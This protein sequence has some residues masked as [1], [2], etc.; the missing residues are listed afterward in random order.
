MRQKLLPGSL[1]N[2]ARVFCPSAH[3]RPFP[4][5]RLPLAMKTVGIHQCKEDW[6]RLPHFLIDCL[7]VAY[8]LEVPRSTWPLR[9]ILQDRE[10]ALTLTAIKIQPLRS[11]WLPLGDPLPLVVQLQYPLCPRSK[12]PHLVQAHTLRPAPPFLKPINILLTWSTTLPNHSRHNSHQ[13][14]RGPKNSRMGRRLPTWR[15]MQEVA[16]SVARPVRVHV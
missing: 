3:L 15:G 14:P 9:S 10:L 7:A 8:Q 13:R 5:P 1:A 2:G 12:R 11:Y 4:R 6:V 16:P